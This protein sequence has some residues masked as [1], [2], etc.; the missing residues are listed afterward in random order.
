[1][2]EQV[3]DPIGDSLG[4]TSIFAALPLVT[5]FVLLGVL[6]MKAWI[7]AREKARK[8]LC[9]SVRRTPDPRLVAIVSACC[10]TLR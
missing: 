8:P 1:M 4:L 7:A 9:E 6:K 2:Y 10:P 3:L 5:L